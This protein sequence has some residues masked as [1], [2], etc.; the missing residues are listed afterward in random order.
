KAVYIYFNN[1]AEAFAVRNAITIGD[2]LP[3]TV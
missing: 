1:D 3:A 2:Y